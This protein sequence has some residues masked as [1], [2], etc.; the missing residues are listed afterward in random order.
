[1]NLP[2]PLKARSSRGPL[3]RIVER[4]VFSVRRSSGLSNQLL[5]EC[6]HVL[7][8]NGSSSTFTSTKRHCA[9][10][11]RGAPQTFRLYDRFRHFDL[12]D[13]KRRNPIENGKA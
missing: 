9:F 13:W 2:T 4:Y 7:V 10:C 1:M 6:G 3:R 11:E 8:R 12:E 5:L